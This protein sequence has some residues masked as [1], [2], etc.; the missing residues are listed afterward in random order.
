[1][2]KPEQHFYIKIKDSSTFFFL[3]PVTF[4]YRVDSRWDYYPIYGKSEVET[5]QHKLE[6]EYPSETYAEIEFWRKVNHLI[7]IYKKGSIYKKGESFD[8]DFFYL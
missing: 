4:S 3:L 6:I 2:W 5:D 8:Y 1:M 7:M